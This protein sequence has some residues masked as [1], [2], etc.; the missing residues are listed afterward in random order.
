MY[1][2]KGGDRGAGIPANTLLQ[3]ATRRF[4]TTRWL[5]AVVVVDVASSLT[6]RGL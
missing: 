2:L 6:T 4:F 1:T 5:V 3:A